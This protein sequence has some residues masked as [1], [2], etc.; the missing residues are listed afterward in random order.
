MDDFKTIPHF[1][2]YAI[3]KDGVIRDDE[4]NE[5]SQYKNDAGYFCCRIVCPNG[6]IK[7][8]RVHRLVILKYGPEIPDWEFRLVNHIDGDKENLHIDNL[9]WSE[10]QH[11]NSHAYLEGL[12]K[13][14]LPFLIFDDLCK[15]EYQVNNTREAT[16]FILGY[17]RDEIYQFIKNGSCSPCKRYWFNSWHDTRSWEEVKLTPEH[18]PDIKR[19]TRYDCGIICYHYDSKTQYI[20]DTLNQ[21]TV[22]TKLNRQT[23]Q[24]KLD[25]Q[26]LKPTKR[27]AFKFMVDSRSF[28]VYTEEELQFLDRCVGNSTPIKAWQIK[29]K[30]TYLFA[31][32]YEFSEFLGLARERASGIRLSVKVRGHYRG[33]TYSKL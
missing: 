5:I 23:I 29:E 4:G 18:K 21:A 20:V 27:W 26:D 15:K 16:K 12:N 28:T 10:F 17:D 30:K 14:G 25:K 22:L 33:W 24:K 3:T 19:Y 9:E 13:N 6:S 8:M 11:N 32:L 2:R 1:H 7:I 31:S